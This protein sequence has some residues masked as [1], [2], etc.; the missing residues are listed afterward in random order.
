MKP[1]LLVLC[2]IGIAGVALFYFVLPGA[3]QQP[4]HPTADEPVVPK[5]K[6]RHDDTQPP[7]QPIL[8]SGAVPEAVT[9]NEATE[10]AETAWL[11]EH[12]AGIVVNQTQQGKL[13]YPGSIK[14]GGVVVDLG[15]TPPLIHHQLKAKAGS[16][17]LGK[18]DDRHSYQR[19]LGIVRLNE[20][21]PQVSYEVSFSY[22]RSATNGGL[23]F[24]RSEAE[25][26]QLGIIIPEIRVPKGADANAPQWAMSIRI[27]SRELNAEDLAKAM[28]QPMGP[29]TVLV[30][31]THPGPPPATARVLWLAL[32][33]NGSFIVAR[34]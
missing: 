29:D 6:Q 10:S 26:S 1:K 19:H 2:L 33:A 30:M 12:S 25:I 18:L 24:K 32:D 34:K 13:Q 7:V 9:S 21:R 8:Q 28:P 15:E 5:L 4:V 22:P 3:N 14:V 27:G 31:P 16:I 11:N 17:L 23:V 20:G